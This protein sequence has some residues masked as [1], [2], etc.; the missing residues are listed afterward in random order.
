MVQAGRPAPTL[1]AQE[2]RFALVLLAPAL[3]ALL[4]TTTAPLVYLVWNSLHRLDLGMPWLSGFA[5]LGNYAKMGSDP[6]FWNSVAAHRGIYTASTVVLRV[7]IGLSGAARAADPQRSGHPAPRRNPA[8]RTRAGG[9]GLFWRT[10]V[11]AP[12]FKA[13][14]SGHARS[15]WAATIGSVTRSCADLSHRRSTLAV[16]CSRFCAAGDARDLAAGCLR[17]RGSIVPAPGSAFA[18]SRCR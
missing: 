6:R 2:R 13:G 10:L 11:L 9:R 14:R 15:A 18:T 5:G 16:D 3:A 4:L 8:D 1:E 12:D 17:G 7:V